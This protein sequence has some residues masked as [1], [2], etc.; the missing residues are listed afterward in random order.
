MNLSITANKTTSAFNFSASQF[1]SSDTGQSFNSV[2]ASMSH[3]TTSLAFKACNANVSNVS[4]PYIAQA[5]TM[6]TSIAATNASSKEPVEPFNINDYYTI[7]EDEVWNRSLA[8]NQRIR[9]NDLSHMSDV[10]AYAWIEKQYI[11][12]FG[13][14]F[15]L[16]YILDMPQGMTKYSII[17]SSFYSAL[18]EQFGLNGVNFGSLTINN[19]NRERLY[20][21]ISDDEIHDIIRAKY[22]ETLS[23]RDFLLMYDEMRSVGL[24]NKEA[25]K[26]LQPGRNGYGTHCL[27]MTITS[28]A[29]NNPNEPWET[30]INK[31]INTSRLFGWYNMWQWQGDY[32]AHPMLTDLMIK[33]FGGQLDDKGWFIGGIMPWDWNYSNSN[34][35]EKLDKANISKP[36]IP[37]LI[38]IL[39]KSLDSRIVSQPGFRPNTRRELDNEQVNSK[40][41]FQEILL[42]EKIKTR[43]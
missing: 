27:K 41:D 9:D 35:D 37:D 12:E 14:N 20:G 18:T 29:Y 34:V 19:I 31:P 8:L 5:F 1:Q 16:A 7:P 33:L 10:E 39:I 42:E 24:F 32:D 6:P 15:M 43:M 4:T 38:D 11:E 21:D 25:E 40:I 13:E 28:L 36:D 26:W 2:L 3:N 22:P 17:G 23:Y 30:Y